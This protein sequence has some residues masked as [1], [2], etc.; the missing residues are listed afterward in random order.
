LYTASAGNMA[1]GVGFVARARHLP[2]S[3]VVPDHAPKTKLA[4]IERLGGRVIAVPFDRWWQVIVEHRYPELDGLFVHPVCNRDVIAGNGT[5]GLEILED[6]PDVDTIVVPYGGGG[7]SSG[8]ASAVRAKAPSVRVLASEV[9]TAA[10]LTAALARC[11]DA[12]LESLGAA[13][14]HDADGDRRLG[15]AAESHERSASVGAAARSTRTGG[16]RRAACVDLA[17]GALGV[18]IAAGRR[19]DAHRD[20]DRGARARGVDRTGARE[21]RCG[22]GARTDSG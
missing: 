22:S 10:P 16:R 11:R 20:R 18:R 17:C 5:I 8:I 13:R 4:A 2:W 6:L 21:R 19:G 9:E 1:Q 14:S 3:V 12:V 7:L 15:A